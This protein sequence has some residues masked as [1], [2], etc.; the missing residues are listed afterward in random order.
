[1]L[2]VLLAVDWSA[3]RTLRH[4]TE[5]AAQQHLTS[6]DRLVQAR[7]PAFDNPAALHD[8]AAW[9]AR[10]GVRTTVIAADGLVLADSDA[11][12][13]SSWGRFSNL[14]VNCCIK[15]RTL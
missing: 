15:P 10:S 14:P 5:L 13:A 4:D 2:G 6:L 7:P 1:M 9:L 11:V 8:W 12:A 3:E